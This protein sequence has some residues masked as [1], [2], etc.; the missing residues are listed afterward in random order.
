MKVLQQKYEQLWKRIASLEVQESRIKSAQTVSDPTLE[1]HLFA[2]PQ[3]KEVPKPKNGFAD[4]AARKDDIVSRMQNSFAPIWDRIWQSAGGQEPSLSIQLKASGGPTKVEIVASPKSFAK[5]VQGK[6]K[7]A[8][9]KL[10]KQ[11]YLEVMKR[12]L[13]LNTTGKSGDIDLP[14]IAGFG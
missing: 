3:S 12:P 1:S 2:I 14:V 6:E 8:L 4:I 9:L 5:V 11:A 7:D 10:F 13:D